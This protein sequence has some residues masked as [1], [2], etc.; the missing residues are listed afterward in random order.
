ME[1][2]DGTVISEIIF[3]RY[4]RNPDGWSFTV[5]PSRSHGFYDAVITNAE[6]SW[7]LKLDTIFKPNPMVLGSKSEV[8]LRQY[9]ASSSLSFGY[10]E[11][12]PW[13][14]R[15][16]EQEDEGAPRLAEL[17]SSL[18]PV[19][20]EAGK[21]YAQGPFVLT[22]GARRGYSRTESQVDEELSSAMLRL[23][24]NRYPGYG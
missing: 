20:P 21:A 17:I 9:A 12:N 14:V 23:L 11:L 8:D 3:K 5:S 16:L 18:A 2:L 1:I 6:E 4:A 7:H 10:R 24:R 19:V 22:R 13:V 15:D